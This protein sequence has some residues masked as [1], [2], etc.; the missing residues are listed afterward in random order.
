MASSIRTLM[1]SLLLS[2]QLV[3]NS[4]C[5]LLVASWRDVDRS[6]QEQSQETRQGA[7]LWEIQAFEP[8]ITEAPHLRLQLAARQLQ[9]VREV[10]TYR[11]F[12]EPNFWAFVVGA[13]L[14][15]LWIPLG[16][17]L[18]Q[19][20][21]TPPLEEPEFFLTLALVAMSLDLLWAMAFLE[22]DSRIE[23]EVLSEWQPGPVQLLPAAAFREVQVS[24]PG[25]SWS[26]AAAFREGWL[27]LP[28]D[29]MPGSVM[30]RDPLQFMIHG[31]DSESVELRLDE[32]QLLSFRQAFREYIEVQPAH[33][34]WELAFADANGDGRLEGE[35]QA[36]ILVKL[37][38][39]G[40]GKAYGLKLKLEADKAVD[41]LDFPET[42]E[43]GTLAAGAS[44][45]YR[46][47][48]QAAHDTPAQAV[49]M[50][51]SLAELNGFEP[52]PK[53]LNFDTAPFRHPELYLADYV[54]EDQNGNGKVEPLEIATVTL[55]LHNRGQGPAENIELQLQLPENVFLTAESKR[56]L[57]LTQLAAGAY[58]DLQF[59]FY[60]N[61]RIGPKLQIG[62]TLQEKHQRYAQSS[63][64]QVAMYQTLR[65][66]ETIRIPAQA[67]TLSPPSNVPDLGS[68]IASDLPQA[69]QLQADAV[70][71]I[72]GNR[73]Y[74]N[75]PEVEYALRD[76]ALM[77][78]YLIQVLG[79]SADNILYYANASKA[80]LDTLFGTR[81]HPRGKLQ[82]WLKAKSP[83]FIY[84][85]GHGAPGPQGQRYL[86]PV[87]ANLDYLPHT[88][89]ALETLYQNLAQ[90]PYGGL[91][92]VIDA[93]F[94]GYSPRGT[95]FPGRSP[96]VLETQAVEPVS[97]PQALVINSAS[98][99]Q[100]SHW[101][102]DK[103]HSLFTYYFLKGLRGEADAN[104]DG[105]L[106]AHEL[107]AYLAQH[108]PYMARR[109]S[110][111]EQEPV[112][113]QQG[114]SII[115]R[116]RPLVR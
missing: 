78:E 56:H 97:L 7:V 58:Q 48:L 82:N 75:A 19:S 84:Y 9:E 39:Q 32:L 25:T 41:F 62:I 109:L 101:Y 16:M 108:I 114:D 51:L 6:L 38:N 1:V 47:P 67:P 44:Q 3:L 83:V 68:E 94:S 70:A 100:L 72:I 52:Q 12:S 53:H 86:V 105:T 55:R 34:S 95:L 90:T 26:T 73:Q 20:L 110:G 93:C 88:G 65:K 61:N 46:I 92:V 91:T 37:H 116:Y 42:F 49:D 115:A 30:S 27:E 36:E 77:R 89:Y 33:L 104:G 112:F 111:G 99:N 69:L 54:I 14:S 35:E 106:T 63:H 57:Q 10:A 43:L 71:V 5:T 40:P 22:G 18:D 24:V 17:M 28:L 107:Q 81:E 29:Q 8:Q 102:D 21:P 31:L 11:E 13:G 87:D 113:W 96:L 50:T 60:T 15:T 74:L 66:A 79:Y 2:L 59:S 23:Q 76:A 45:S 85:T 98:Q 64:V 4:G 80:D 103:R